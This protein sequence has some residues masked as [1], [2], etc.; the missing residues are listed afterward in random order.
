[1]NTLT[2]SL[3]VKIIEALKLEDMSPE[4]IE[5]E[6]ALFGQGL[7]LDSI[8]ALELVVMLERE[9]GIKI[10]DPRIAREA[11]SSVKTLAEFVAKNQGL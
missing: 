6:A 2:H 10:E 8:D 9:Y 4:A 3:K 7:G 5:D 11:F 1:M